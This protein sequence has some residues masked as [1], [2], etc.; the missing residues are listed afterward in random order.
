MVRVQIN[1]TYLKGNSAVLTKIKTKH[2]P[3]LTI[4]H[5]YLHKCLWCLLMPQELEAT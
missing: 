4:L 3:L 2:I 5:K 1:T